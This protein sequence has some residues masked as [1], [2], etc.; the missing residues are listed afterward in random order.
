MQT[1]RDPKRS[2][3]ALQDA[4]GQFLDKQWH[5]V[6]A[7]D[8]LGDDLVRQYLAAGDL[9]DQGGPVM[10]VQ[11]IEHQHADLRLAGPGRLEFGAER[12]DQ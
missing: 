1:R 8:D 7:I 5:A 10:P 12:H 11:A 9:L 4:L 6:G 3:P 2:H